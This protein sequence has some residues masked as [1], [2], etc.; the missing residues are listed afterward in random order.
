MILQMLSA[1]TYVIFVFLLTPAPF[2]ADTK[3]TPIPN[4]VDTKIHKIQDFHTKTHIILR[5]A[6]YF[7]T[8]D[9]NGAGDKSQV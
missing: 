4:F 9:A 1:H 3:N 5:K 2:S 8:G 7:D 6:E